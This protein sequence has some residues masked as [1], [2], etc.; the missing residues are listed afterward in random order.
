LNNRIEDLSKKLF[1]KTEE[2]DEL[3]NKYTNL[4]TTLNTER[5][6]EIRSWSRRQD[7]IKRTIEELKHQL[8]D[9][10]NRRDTSLMMKDEEHRLLGDEVKLLRSEGNKMQAFWEG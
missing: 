1:V 2:Y 3:Q 5:H 6:E 7:Q 8:E 10:R 4:L 9:T